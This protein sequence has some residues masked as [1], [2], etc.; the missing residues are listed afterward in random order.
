MLEKNKHI[1]NELEQVS[2]VLITAHVDTSLLFTVPVNY[3]RDLSFTILNAITAENLKQSVTPYQV[4]IGYF[5]NLSSTILNKIASDNSIV[6]AIDSELQTIAPLLNTISKANIY[7]VPAGY[8]S[9]LNLVQTQ[10]PHAKIIAL[11][12]SKKWV[13]YAVAACLTGILVAGAFMVNNKNGSVDYA[14]YKKIDV[15]NSINKLSSEELI[16][17]LD[18]V[19]S[20]TNANFATTLDIKLP[21]I[22]DHIQ[23]ISDEELDQYLQEANLPLEKSDNK[24]GI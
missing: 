13:K 6:S 8:F 1:I 3:F 2:P 21:E 12:S 24:K 4:P 16:N 17:Y 14:A 9:A 7:S 20:I 18:N 5:D 22:Q 10:Q 15:I 19:N 11:T 23:L